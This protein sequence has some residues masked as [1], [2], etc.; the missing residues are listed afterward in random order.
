MAQKTC[1]NFHSSISTE[2]CSAD[3]LY[4]ICHL[5]TAMFL[6]NV[7]IFLPVPITV[8][9]VQEKLIK[10]FPRAHQVVLQQKAKSLQH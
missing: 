3:C 2:I 7:C 4:L 9:I 10:R 6:L 8:G 5:Y 1:Y